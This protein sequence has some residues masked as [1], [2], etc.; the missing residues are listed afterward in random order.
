MRGRTLGTVCSSNAV[1]E[2]VEEIQY[3]LGEGPCVDAFGSREPV[4][5]PDLAIEGLTRWPGFGEGAL[6]EGVRA[7]F[8]FPV[9]VGSACIGALNL[10]QDTPGRLT[11]EQVAD[12]LVVA[13]VAGRTV[14]E[15]QSAADAGSLAHQLEHL[16][17][18]RA[19]VHQASGMVSV[20]ATV[21]IA[22]AIALL[23]AVAFSTDRSISE[24]ATDVV[25]RAL[26]FD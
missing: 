21:A 11:D 2:R 15:W 5:V 7:A 25:R 19:V 23:R 14:V 16:P 24:V 3:S 26:R 6:A 13:H 17:E 22:D 1:T 12:A 10:Y 18:R 9:L 20:Q 4:L 8:G